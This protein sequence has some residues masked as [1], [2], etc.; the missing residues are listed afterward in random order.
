MM[1]NKHKIKVFMLLVV[2]TI[3]ISGC[4]RIFI[5]DNMYA[6]RILYDLSFVNMSNDTIYVDADTCS[7]GKQIVPQELSVYANKELL[8]RLLPY[9]IWTVQQEL[10]DIKKGC[11]WQYFVL[12][13]ST[14]DKYTSEELRDQNICDSVLVFTY[15]DICR[16]GRHLIY[17]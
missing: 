9:E 12:K 10:Y 2:L 8:Y 15:E 11:T 16:S 13:K 6:D 5:P 17:K 4:E 14:Y 3:P 1:K 7:T